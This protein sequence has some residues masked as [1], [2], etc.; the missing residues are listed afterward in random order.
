MRFEPCNIGS[1]IADQAKNDPDAPCIEQD[2]TCHSRADVIN[3]AQMIGAFF[4]E[5]GVCAG[6][7][8]A[9]V[10]VDRLKGF[11]AM[12]ALWSLEA[13]VLF[14]DPRQSIDEINAAIEIAGVEAV[15]TDSKSFAR[16]GG[17]GLFPSSGPSTESD[18]ELHFRSDS[19][20]RDALILSSSGT[21]GVPRYRRVSHR[22]FMEGL[23]VAGQLLDNQ[24]PYP[25][26]SVGSLAFGAILSD[27]IKLTT[28]GKFLLSLPLFFKVTEL[29]QAIARKDIQ[30]LK[31][32][33]VSIRDLLEFHSKN[34]PEEAGPVYPHI[35]HIYSVGG[36]ISADDLVQAYRVLTPG[37]RNVYSMSGVGTVSA[38]SGDAILEKPNSV[39]KP[40]AGVTVRIEEENGA[41]CTAGQ[42]GRI[43]AKPEW[44]HDAVTIDTG[45][46]G[47]FDD[48]GFLFIHG[49]SA[50]S[51]T[52]NSINVN[53]ADLE[54]DVNRITGVRDC[55]AFSAQAGASP[56]DLVFLAIET[57]AE[58]HQIKGQ[59]KST[60]ASYRQPDKITVRAQLPRNASN[61]IA[62]HSLRNAALEKDTPFVDF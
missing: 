33:P 8:I 50:Q 19:Y 40:F 42:I 59:I 45:D 14:L 61:K 26:V 2:G 27:W 38:L 28:H 21:T 5:Q 55:I 1:L 15:F 62:L 25:A 29:H 53:L 56:D 41:I 52:R 36:P 18:F 60:L 7:S 44:K 31:L 11:E 49:R 12:V 3:A 34:T 13:A 35:K 54:R 20:D 46:I 4:K 23:F 57:N 17:Y 16:R 47:W 48:D 9:I 37:I 22:A 39:G 6:A 51:A 10:A 30:S 43:V 24:T 32:P 58:A